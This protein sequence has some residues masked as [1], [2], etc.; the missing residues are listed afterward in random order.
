ML[1]NC[2]HTTIHS[3]YY[4]VCTIHQSM[5]T[6]CV[7]VAVDSL[8]P[9][10]GTSIVQLIGFRCCDLG[11]SDLKLLAENWR[12]I[13]GNVNYALTMSSLFSSKILVITLLQKVL[14]VQKLIFILF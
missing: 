10:D 6:F 2:D 13:L 4:N 5:D 9:V 7:F 3:L 1:Y 8:S 14:R 12:K 11:P